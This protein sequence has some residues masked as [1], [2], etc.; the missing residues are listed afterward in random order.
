[1]FLY[2]NVRMFCIF[3]AITKKMGLFECK[4]TQTKVSVEK[5]C[6]NFLLIIKNPVKC[7]SFSSKRL[8]MKVAFHRSGFSLKRLFIE[9]AFH[10][11]SFSSKRLFIEAA[12][13]QICNGGSFSSNLVKG[14]SFNEKMSQCQF[15]IQHKN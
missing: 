4:S 8:F 12:F 11:S 9:A 5:R 15:I 13:H 7:K 6:F 3:L 1:M 2:D 14:G 10:Q